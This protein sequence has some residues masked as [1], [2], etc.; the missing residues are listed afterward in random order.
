MIHVHSSTTDRYRQSVLRRG[1]G[2]GVGVAP[3]LKHVFHGNLRPSHD[4]QATTPHGIIWSIYAHQDARPLLAR[5]GEDVGGR[6]H[7]RVATALVGETEDGVQ[8]PHT[9]YKP[10]GVGVE[11]DTLNVA[12]VTPIYRVDSGLLCVAQGNE[13]LFLGRRQRLVG[14]LPRV[15]Q[16]TACEWDTMN[17]PQGRS[18]GGAGGTYTRRRRR[19]KVK[20]AHVGSAPNVCRSTAARTGSPSRDCLDARNSVIAR[21]SGSLNTSGPQ[22]VFDEGLVDEPAL[23]QVRAGPLLRL[24]STPCA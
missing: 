14:H 13:H 6:L 11:V 20:T 1:V 8:F 17:G 7:V 12:E 2:A 9:V 16:Q 10:T 19:Q 22:Y 24:R 18:A 21:S 23:H 3:D 15:Q 4:G 5:A